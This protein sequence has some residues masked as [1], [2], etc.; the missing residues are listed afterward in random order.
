MTITRPISD[1]NMTVIDTDFSGIP[2]RLYL[3]KRRSEKWRPA[4]IFF[5]GGAFVMGS[6][7]LQ[8]YDFLNRLVAN[9]LDAV[10]VGV[11]YRLAPQYHFPVPLEDSIS[12]VKFF[13]QDKILTKYGV[14]STRVCIS[15]DSSGGTLAAQ[16]AQ[17]LKKDPEFKDKI[18]AQA[19]IY[20]G[21]QLFDTLMPSHVENE[22]GPVLPRDMLIKLASLYVTKD[23]ALPQ[24]MWKNQYLPQ[25]N[26]YLLKFV[27]WSVFLPEK[28]KKNHVYIEPGTGELTAPYFR[29]ID[30][31]SPLTANDFELQN[32]PLTYVLT[33][34]H[35][36]LRDDGLIY[37]TRLRNAGVAVSHDHIEDGIH[38]ALAFI[39]SPFHLHVGLRIKDKYIRWLEENL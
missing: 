8:V 3:P 22:H 35:D 9:K 11:D 32:L 17:V 15:G 2:V 5:H 14:D 12:A 18:K 7:K 25:E 29:F 36:I 1:E 16:V 37:V 6:C 21:L 27:N 23:Q 10:V 24:A 19:L 31:M 4:V 20:P 39:L 13:L 26:R 33:C 30:Q 38:G 28:Y 34:E